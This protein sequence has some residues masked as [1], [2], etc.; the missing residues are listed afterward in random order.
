MNEQQTEAPNTGEMTQE[1]FDAILLP[2]ALDESYRALAH[3]ARTAENAEA[4]YRFRE[5]AVARWKK[6]LVDRHGPYI[7]ERVQRHCDAVSARTN[8]LNKAP[9]GE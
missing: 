1:L 8:R 7:V 5:A 3:R 6:V 2:I 4:Q 9:H